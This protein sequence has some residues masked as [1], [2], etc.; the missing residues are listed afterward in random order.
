MKSAKE[1]ARNSKTLANCPDLVLGYIETDFITYKERLYSVDCNGVVKRSN[2]L[3]IPNDHFNKR[4]RVWHIVDELPDN[5][6][7]CGNYP[8]DN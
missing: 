4:G 7:F 1:I 2:W 5:V 8:N 6:E 3:K